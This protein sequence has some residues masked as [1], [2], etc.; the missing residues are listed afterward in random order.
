MM[1]FFCPILSF[2]GV[3]ATIRR[4]WQW[5]FSIQNTSCV[6]RGGGERELSAKR[7]DSYLMC[8]A[9]FSPSAYAVTSLIICWMERHNDKVRRLTSHS[10][11]NGH[12]FA[13]YMTSLSA[14]LEWQ[15]QIESKCLWTYMAAAWTFLSARSSYAS[16]RFPVIRIGVYAHIVISGL[17]FTQ[18]R[19]LLLPPCPQHPS[20]ILREPPSY[21]HMQ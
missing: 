19:C 9:T 21:A 8:M 12:I 3:K 15:K 14:N 2:F 6:C 20:H 4:V 10:W 16:V 5:S 11:T 17:L 1:E 7:V 13:H 18:S